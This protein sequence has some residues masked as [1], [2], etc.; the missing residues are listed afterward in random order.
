[1]PR[2]CTGTAAVSLTRQLT[3]KKTSLVRSMRQQTV[4]WQQMS[5]N[6][7]ER[8]WIGVTT[9]ATKHMC[10]NVVQFLCRRSA[11]RAGED[12]PDV[13][14]RLVCTRLVM[15]PQP[16]SAKNG[17]L[18]SGADIP[19]EGDRCYSPLPPKHSDDKDDVMPGCHS[20][21]IS[22]LYLLE[23]EDQKN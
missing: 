14:G 18:Q 6:C 8:L 17:T 13:Q 19:G 23:A 3:R 9:A 5:A 4:E 16:P 20:H 12:H 21:Y 22:G 2:R 11:R 15:V 7:R 1:M 10:N